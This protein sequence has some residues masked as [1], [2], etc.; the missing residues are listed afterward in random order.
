MKLEHKFVNENYEKVIKDLKKINREYDSQKEV[1]E[2]VK[3][4]EEQL[5]FTIDR[6]LG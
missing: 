4:N 2:N 3:R 5:K 6:L 1:M